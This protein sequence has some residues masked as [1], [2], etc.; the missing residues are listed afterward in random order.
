MSR[1][2]PIAGKLKNKRSYQVWIDKIEPKLFKLS[3]DI[4]EKDST[5]GGPLISIVVPCFNTPE[6]YLTPLLESVISQTYQNWQLCLTDGST[7]QEIKSNIKKLSNQDKRITYIDVQE[8][9]GIAGNTNAGI[10]NAKGEFVAFL[11][12]DDTLSPYALSEVV[13]VLNWNPKLDLIYSDEDKLTDDGAKRKLPFFKPNWSPDLLLGVNYITHFVVARKSIIDE[14]GGLRQGFDGAQ[15]YDFL[16]RF[17]EKTDRIGHVPKILYHWRLADGSTSKE[18]GEKDYADTAGRRALADAVKRRKINA[19]VLEIEDRPTNYR[20]RYKLPSKQPKVS[21]VIPFKDKP[22][23]LKQCVGS[24]LSKTTYDNYEIILVSNNSVEATTHDYLE[25]LKKHA[26]CKVFY[27]DHPFNYSAINNF[28]SKQAAGDYLVLLNNDTK[29]ITENWLEE[30]VGVALQEGVG[31]VGPVLYYPDMTIQH[32]GI[33]V[34]MKYM[35]GHVFRNRHLMDWT[36]FGMPAWPRNYM[37]VTGACLVIELAKY[38]E[39]GGLDE[40]FVVA[41][42]DVSLGIKLHEAGYRNVYWPFAGLI[43]YENISVGSYDNGIQLDYD[44]SL[45]YYRPYLG[46]KDPYFNSNLDIMNEQIGLDISSMGGVINKALHT[47]RNHG[48]KGVAMKTRSSVKYQLRVLRRLVPRRSKTMTSKELREEY[49]FVSNEIFQITEADI[50]KSNE[51]VAKHQIKGVATANWFVPNFD[52]LSFGGIFTIFRFIEKFSKEGVRNRIIIYDNPSFDTKKLKEDISLKFP[53]LEGYE[54]IIFDPGSQNLDDLPEC[55]IAICTFWVSAYLLLKFNKAKRKYYFI[56][57]Y[58]P[59]FYQAGST[60]AL[61]ESTYRFGFRGLVNTPG[62]LAAVNQRHGMEGISFIPA[63]DQT[64]YRPLTYQRAD[65]KVRVFF[66]ARPHNPRN[67]FNLCVDIMKGLIEKYGDKIEII[68]AGANWSEADFGLKGKI[69]NLGLL[70]SLD[71]VADLY[72]N[73]DIG[74]VYMLSKHPSYQPFEF[75]AS[76]MATVTNNNE[77]NLWLLKD[78]VNC[79]LSEPSPAAMIEKISL[80]V[81]DKK[82]RGEIAKNGLESL[83]YTWGQQTAMIWNELNK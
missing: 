32:A 13:N 21:I 30:L 43:H 24:I 35:A 7:N 29:V 45:K 53:K 26:K 67:A 17:T 58:E 62:L 65:K 20:L 59:L 81:E 5:A 73:C 37:A 39:M 78:G 63:V 83:G 18:V 11:D 70:K 77:D 54:L 72:R 12:H 74:F 79:L 75:M 23:L 33:V 15:D 47:Y 28:G 51:Q 71:E 56:Q 64:Q 82:L 44:H 68:T 60:Y 27:W 52:H 6:K 34:G 40:T 22:D 61:A 46:G 3:A 14:I 49:A 41:G 10:A 4:S 76:G 69:L 2:L 19:E 9:L 50:R 42:N 80:L 66:Y 55:D 36:D 1:L 8:N 38:R 57:D 48:P 31:A 25:T 16:L